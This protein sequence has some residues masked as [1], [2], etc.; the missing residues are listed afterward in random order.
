MS[1]V[2][3]WKGKPMLKVSTKEVGTVVRDDNWGM[4]RTFTLK[5]KDGRT[6]QFTVANVGPTETQDYAWWYKPRSGKGEWNVWS[7][8]EPFKVVE[9]PEP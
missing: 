4:G 5:F 6:E 7:D 2:G 9:G 1:D 3:S 8:R